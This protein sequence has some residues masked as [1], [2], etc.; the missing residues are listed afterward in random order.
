MVFSSVT[1]VSD[2]DMKRDTTDV[3]HN[4]SD[5]NHRLALPAG[6]WNKVNR[7]FLEG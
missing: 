6:S 1:T 3:Q 7:R 4:V 2:C 5:K